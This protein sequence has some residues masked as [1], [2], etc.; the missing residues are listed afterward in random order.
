MPQG[1]R[2]FPGTGSAA[3]IRDWWILTHG[4]VSPG[5]VMLKLGI[6]SG[7]Q[8]RARCPGK[9][10]HRGDCTTCTAPQEGKYCNLCLSSVRHAGGVGRAARNTLAFT[11]RHC[12]SI[13]FLQPGLAF[14]HARLRR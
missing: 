6:E 9:G 12:D 2:V 14:K 13:D 7:D 8:G 1:D 11:V 5:C 10:D 3:S 4:L